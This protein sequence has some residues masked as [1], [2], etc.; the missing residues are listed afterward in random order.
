MCKDAIVFFNKPEGVE[1]VAGETYQFCMCGRSADG[2]FCDGSHEG[3]GCEPKAF[4]VEKSKAYQ[5]CRCKSSDNL[6][7]CNGNHSYYADSA[8][9]KKVISD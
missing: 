7:F 3:T 1:L 9:G 5:L 6:P 2:L 4:S 8:V